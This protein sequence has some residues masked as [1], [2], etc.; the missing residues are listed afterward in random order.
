MSKVYVVFGEDNYNDRRVQ[1]VCSTREK[2]EIVK[3]CLEYDDHFI[4]YAIDEAEIDEILVRLGKEYDDKLEYYREMNR[5][6]EKLMK[7]L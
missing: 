6:Y 7:E 1:G 5:L 2:A 4:T 3:E